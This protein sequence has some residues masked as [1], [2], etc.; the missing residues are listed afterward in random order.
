[1]YLRDTLATLL[2]LALSAHPTILFF[3]G[4]A[5]TRA[6]SLRTRLYSTLTSRLNANVLAID[7]RGFGD[8][9]GTPSEQ[10]L[11]LDAHAAW[12]WLIENGAK[13]G[14][15]TVIGQSLGTGVSAG[16]VAELAEEG[17]SI[18]AWLC[19]ISN[20]V[21]IGISPRGLVLISP[22]TS[23]ATLLETYNMGG[24]LP[25]LQPLQR[26]RFAFGECYCPFHTHALMLRVGFF[27][28]FLRHQFNTLSL[29][30][31]RP[32][33]VLFLNLTRL[34]RI[35]HAQLSSFMRRMTG[36]FLLR[37]PRLFLIRCLNH[38]FLP[39]R[40]IPKTCYLAK[41]LT[42]N[43]RKLSKIEIH[44]KKKL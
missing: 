21:Q 27:I 37:T 19:D 3:H 38:C 11:L 10:G 34:F 24:R 22:Y 13:K 16:L 8:S 26:F 25:I 28:K 14:D 32:I 1:M 42:R 9:A 23:I 2:P 35:L 4:N 5:M 12:D 29:I 36:T 18:V 7:Y 33:D 31:V 40:L 39:I 44:V 15:I 6:F 41:F 43:F 20:L 17:K 30:N